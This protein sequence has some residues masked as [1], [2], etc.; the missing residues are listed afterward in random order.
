MQGVLA[1]RGALAPETV[2]HGAGGLSPVILVGM[3]GCGK[4]T[5]GRHVAR[6]LGLRFV[7]S[8]QE[9]ERQLGTSIRL[10]F[11]QHGEDSFRDAEQQVIA[12]LLTQGPVVLATGGG[13]VL[14][15]ATRQAFRDS[16]CRVVYLR[17]SPEELARRLRHDT[18][19]P[20]LQGRDPLKTL[21]GLFEVRDPLYREVADYVVDTGRTSV[22]TLSS[23]LVMQLEL[24]PAQA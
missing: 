14:R 11:E 3:P 23:L 19:R 9:L 15:A 13:A 10:F 4:S 5:V 22:H 12:Q 6:L 2:D 21:R 24:G 18:Q 17:A 20:L 7:D 16:V 1:H 8:D